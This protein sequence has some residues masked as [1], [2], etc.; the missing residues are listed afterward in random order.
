EF[1][2]KVFDVSADGLVGS[3]LTCSAIALWRP[4]FESWLEDLSRSC[5]LLSLPLCDL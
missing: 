1:E 3:L 4:E 2:E 5:P